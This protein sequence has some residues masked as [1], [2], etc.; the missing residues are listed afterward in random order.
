MNNLEYARQQFRTGQYT[1][2]LCR[3]EITYTSNANGISPL[4]DFMENGC[5]LHGFSAA[6][7][8]VGKAAAML[9]ALAG[10][11]E[12]HAQVMSKSAAEV[13]RIHKIAFSYDILTE[14]IIN[15]K[16]DDICPMEQAV[17]QIDMADL[18]AAYIAISAKREELR[19]EVH[20]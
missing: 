4:L 3:G 2:V 8:I 12:L 15:R 18:Q 9:F 17:A 20:Q 16:G 5:N 6:D 11:T 7:K 10:I 1:C 13:L 19:K 14:H